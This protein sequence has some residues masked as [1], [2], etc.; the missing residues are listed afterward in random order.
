MDKYQNCTCSGFD[1]L[2]YGHKCQ[3]GKNFQ[4]IIL[5][6]KS[7]IDKTDWCVGD[8]SGE[9]DEKIWIDKDTSLLCMIYRDKRMGT[10]TGAVGVETE[11]RLF[12]LSGQ[13]NISKILMGAN[14]ECESLVHSA[15]PDHHFVSFDSCCSSAIIPAFVGKHSMNAGAVYYDMDYMTNTVRDLASYIKK[16]QMS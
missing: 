6:V 13:F 2:N 15:Y 11:D 7:N 3:N 10:L 4:D 14:W 8:W 5:S 1:L 16:R 12:G 9:I